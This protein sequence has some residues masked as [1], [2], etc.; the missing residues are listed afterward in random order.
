[1]SAA[2]IP[3]PSAITKP[4]P[5]STDITVVPR[6]AKVPANTAPIC[7]HETLAASPAYSSEVSANR[8]RICDHQSPS[9]SKVELIGRP[10]AITKRLGWTVRGAP[11]PA[12]DT[13]TCSASAGHRLAS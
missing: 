7:N 9:H 3:R 6:P 4:W 2:L 12:G 13:S 10:S 11:R 8:G 1:M 5:L